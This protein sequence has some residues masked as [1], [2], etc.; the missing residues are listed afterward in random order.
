MFKDISFKQFK[1]EAENATSPINYAIKDGNFRKL[2]N[3]NIARVYLND[4]I[5]FLKAK[6]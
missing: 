1:K 5:Y 6:K 3:K 4:I 2:P